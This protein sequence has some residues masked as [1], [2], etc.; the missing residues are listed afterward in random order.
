MDKTKIKKTLKLLQE[1]RNDETHFYV[2]HNGFLSE[3]NF[4]TL[5]EFMIDFYKLLNSWTP[6][7]K[8]IEYSL[9]PYNVDDDSAFSFNRSPLQDFTYLMAVKNAPLVKQIKNLFKSESLGNPEANCFDIAKGIIEK[10]PEYEGNTFIVWT[11]IQLM[12]KFKI[13]KTEEIFDDENLFIQYRIV[14]N[15]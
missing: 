1:L 7:N 15:D 10:H 14:V 3:E 12:F 9:L 2:S 13:I 8:G 6:K 11:Y 4:I 5:Y